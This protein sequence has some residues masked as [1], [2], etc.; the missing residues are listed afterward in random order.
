MT[1]LRKKPSASK[2]YVAIC[3]KTNFE[4]YYF[5]KF[6][7]PE[8]VENSIGYATW[9]FLNQVDFTASIEFVLTYEDY[10]TL[11]VV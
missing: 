11:Y 8:N 4:G 7:L 5:K 6:T 1:K 10:T 2:T 9:Y 3:N